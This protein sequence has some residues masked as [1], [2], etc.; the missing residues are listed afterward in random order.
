MRFGRWIVAAGMLAVMP[1]MAQAPPVRTLECREVRDAW[2]WSHPRAAAVNFG[3]PSEGNGGLHNV[4][5]A[6][7]WKWGRS[8]SDT[9]RALLAFDLGELPEGAIVLSARLKLSFYAN[10]GFT[11]HLGDNALVISRVTAPWREDAVTWSNQPPATEHNAVRVGPSSDPRQDY[12][13][14]DLRNIVQEWA[15]FP[16]SNHGVMLRLEREREFNGVTFASGDHSSA[17]L[18]PLLVITYYRP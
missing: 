5:R 10:D 14:I 8:E 6:E 12:P 13:D 4:I 2:I 15:Y 17:A 1:A 9:I 7:V 3:V 18:R 11:P 16:G